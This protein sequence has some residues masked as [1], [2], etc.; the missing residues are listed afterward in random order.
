MLFSALSEGEAYWEASFEAA[1]YKGGM[2]VRPC[3]IDS[4]SDLIFEVRIVTMETIG[5]NCFHYSAMLTRS[6]DGNFIQSR[7][8]DS[9]IVEDEREPELHTVRFQSFGSRAS[10]LGASQPSGT[11]VRKTVSWK[12]GFTCVSV[13]DALAMR[14]ALEFAGKTIMCI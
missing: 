9:I 3:S 7:P 6:P 13:P 5:C 10:S 8:R 2:M 1:N 12:G 11:I 4:S 14:T